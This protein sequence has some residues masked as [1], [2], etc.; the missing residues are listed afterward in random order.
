MSNSS[1]AQGLE[2]CLEHPDYIPP[3]KKPV[4][5]EDQF[6][7]VGLLG[8]VQFLLRDKRLEDSIEEQSE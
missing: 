8:T 1:A 7:P 3:F 5:F 6:K 4:H 2:P